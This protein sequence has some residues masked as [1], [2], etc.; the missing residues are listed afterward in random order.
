MCRSIEKS[1]SHKF[2]ILPLSK[3]FSTLSHRVLS[4]ILWNYAFFLNVFVLHLIDKYWYYKDL[5]CTLTGHSS[6]ND[7]SDSYHLYWLGPQI[8]PRLPH[9][10]FFPIPIAASPPSHPTNP[11]DTPADFDTE[12]K[13]T[14]IHTS[15]KYT[16]YIPF[17][18]T[19][20]TLQLILTLAGGQNTD[21]NTSW[22]D[23]SDSYCL[24]W[25]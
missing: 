14:K 13:Q 21:E 24:Y 6:W 8:P 18:P 23:S 17:P 19:P 25:L 1:R 12:E 10:Q 5:D 22:N 16:L 3:T 20:L 15:Y 2:S 4:E 7:G 9:I 11:L